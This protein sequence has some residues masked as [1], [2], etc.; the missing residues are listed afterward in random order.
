L[1][2]SDGQGAA[3]DRNTNDHN[4]QPSVIRLVRFGGICR[5]SGLGGRLCGLCRRLSRLRGGFCGNR[6]RLGRLRGRLGHG[7]LGHGRLGHGRLGYRRF[8][9]RRLGYR[10][11]RGLHITA[12]AASTRN[13]MMFAGSRDGLPLR[14]P[15][16][17]IE[18]VC[19]T[20]VTIASTGGICCT[21]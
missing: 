12:D 8:G 20:G 15:L 1:G 16:V 4:Y 19:I 10:G 3:A 13:I 5:G 7:R 6:R 14:N 21:F 11:F 9:H 18:A 17:A 2:K